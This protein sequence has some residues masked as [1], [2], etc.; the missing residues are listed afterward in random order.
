[1]LKR[2][3]VRV[4]AVKAV[5]L[6]YGRVGA[7]DV[8]PASRPVA[9]LGTDAADHDRLPA[10]KWQPHNRTSTSHQGRQGL[11]S[12]HREHLSLVKTLYVVHKGSL[13]T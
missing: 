2:G 13:Q 6:R 4:V 8:L 9:Q 3:M 1:M 12:T 5:K 10:L 11:T 7:S